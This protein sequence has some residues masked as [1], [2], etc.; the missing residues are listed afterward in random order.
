MNPFQPDRYQ[1]RATPET[2]LHMRMCAHTCVCLLVIPL[3][4][5][6]KPKQSLVHNLVHTNYALARKF[7][8]IPLQSQ[9]AGNINQLGLFSE[10]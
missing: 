3:N 1:T 4:L 2:L 7:M 8:L 9:T 5:M 10:Q 6:R